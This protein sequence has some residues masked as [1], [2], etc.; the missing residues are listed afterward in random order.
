MCEIL[1]LMG[2]RGERKIKKKE[3]KRFEEERQPEDRESTIRKKGNIAL[4]SPEICELELSYM[5]LILG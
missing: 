4:Q 3:R 2:S 5:R 1:F